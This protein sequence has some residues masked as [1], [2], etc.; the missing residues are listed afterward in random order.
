MTDLG[1]NRL[2]ENIAKIRETIAESAVRAGRRPEEIIL[3]AASK[4]QS[5]QTVKIASN[6]NIDIFGENRVQE[7]TE[8]Y[9]AGAYG[10]KKVHMIG[11]LQTNKVRQT[12]GRADIIESVD[13]KHLLDAI[14]AEAAKHEICQK[15]MIEIKMTLK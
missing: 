12:V 3:C 11:H 2:R 1:E 13:S 9:D 14:C 15:I 10:E 8:K 4:T 7:L 6:L 5:I